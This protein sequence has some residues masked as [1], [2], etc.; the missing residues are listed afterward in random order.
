MWH[1]DA[2]Q[3]GIVVRIP[4]QPWCLAC[5][6]DLHM[7]GGGW[8]GTGEGHE[9]FEFGV[10]GAQCVLPDMYDTERTLL[11]DQ[12]EA[13][14]PVVRRE[15]RQEILYRAAKNANSCGP[16]ATWLAEPAA[17]QPVVSFHS[18]GSV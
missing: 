11:R 7:E 6:D 15:Q 14:T 5:I 8:G 1:S 4:F 17:K 2:E 9:D 10:P 12:A 16:F 18:S 3:M 13:T